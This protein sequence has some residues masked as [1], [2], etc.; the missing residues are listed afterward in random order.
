MQIWGKFF[1]F[2][3]FQNRRCN[4]ISESFHPCKYCKVFHTT[5]TAPLKDTAQ[6]NASDHLTRIFTNTCT[7]DVKRYIYVRKAI[8]HNSKYQ[9]ITN[10]SVHALVVGKDSTIRLRSIYV[11]FSCVLIVMQWSIVWNLPFI[12]TQKIHL[13]I[14][15]S[16]LSVSSNRTATQSIGLR[17]PYASIPAHIHIRTHVFNFISCTLRYFLGEINYWYTNYIVHV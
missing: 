15:S 16:A 9:Y 11:T 13:L 2:W 4:H 1:R 3:N 8:L 17:D 5:L 14:K 6:C 12:G 10:T 7:C